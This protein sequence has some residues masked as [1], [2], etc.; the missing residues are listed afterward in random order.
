MS[1]RTAALVLVLLAAG[2]RSADES[3]GTPRGEPPEVRIRLQ[4]ASSRKSVRIT[5]AGRYR[6]RE[7]G[8]ET[9]SGASLDLRFPIRGAAL[10]R[11]L[12]VTTEGA[13]I[14]VDGKPYPGGLL[15]RPG[16]SGV[17]LIVVTDL[18][19]YLP[20]V[21]AKELAPAFPPAALRAQAI[22]ARTYAI[23]VMRRRRRAD[24]YDL[25]DD[26]SDQ[27][28][29]GLVE[30]R[31]GPLTR[32]VEETRGMVLVHRSMPFKAFY[33]STCGGHTAEKREVFGGAR[34][35]ALSGVPCVWCRKSKH[36]RW[37]NDELT[38]EAVQRGLGLPGP[39][40]AASVSRRGRGR[41]ATRIR[42]LVPEPVEMDAAEVRNRL[43]P[44]VLKSTLI[45]EITLAGGRVRF[46]GGGYGHG[47]GMCQM[48]ATGMAKA[49]A[50]PGDIL[51]HYYP[52]ADLQRFY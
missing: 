11:A 41:R 50:S 36:Y 52:G 2:C 17:D 37:T 46:E 6:I 23:H 9:E 43:G 4:S 10:P 33:H 13:A 39:P 42:F 26:T 21:L 30:P 19:S 5:V 25:R 49:G 12:L 34:L 32:A 1:A 24:G 38:A 45:F 7:G 31:G 18:E 15:L 51:S 40:Q 28:Y 16:A 44:N 27:A 48:G 35:P 22:A 29:G 20:G 3:A 8:R 14:R 47:V